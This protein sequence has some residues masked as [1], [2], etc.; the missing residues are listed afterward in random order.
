MDRLIVDHVTLASFERDEALVVE[1]F[2]ALFVAVFD[3][4]VGT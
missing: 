2:D 4:V 1:V 3:A